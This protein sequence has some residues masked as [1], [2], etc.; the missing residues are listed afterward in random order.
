MSKN[1][2]SNLNSTIK[3]SARHRVRFFYDN[4]STGWQAFPVGRGEAIFLGELSVPEHAGKTMRIAIAHVDECE[5]KPVAL[6][7]VSIS[8]WKIGDDGLADQDEQMRHIVER[9]NGE[10]D[11]SG[12]SIVTKEDIEAIKQCLGFGSML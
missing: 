1:S 4:P 5:N 7:N 3:N 8:S 10:P 2:K 12:D 11:T 9:I 6:N